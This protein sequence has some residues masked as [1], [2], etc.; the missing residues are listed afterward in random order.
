MRKKKML[1]YYIVVFFLFAL[2]FGAWTRNQAF[3][4]VSHLLG[5]VAAVP[6]DTQRAQGLSEEKTTQLEVTGSRVADDDGDDDDDDDDSDD[7]DSSEELS[8]IALVAEHSVN[9]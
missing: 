4:S 3:H 2:N 9:G 1:C 7:G 5:S 6:V 8:T